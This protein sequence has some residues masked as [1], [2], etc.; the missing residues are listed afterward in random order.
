[1]DAL[2]DL[3][4]AG[5]SALFES[6]VQPLAFSLGLGHWLEIAFEGTGWLLV[7]LLQLAVML[8][9]ILP[10]ELW[11]PAEPMRDPGAVR[12]DVAYT[13]FHRLGVFRLLLFFTLDPLAD[14]LFG[15]LRAAG[16]SGIH[17]DDLWP[18]WSDQPAVA[19]VLYLLLFDAL[20]YAIHRGQHHWSWW[21]ALHALHHSQRQMTMWTDQRNHLLD[22]VLVAL[23]WAVVAQAVGMPPEQFVAVVAVTQLLENL[24]HANVRMSFG[25]WGERCLISPRFHRWHHSVGWGHESHARGTGV[26]DRLPLGGHNFGVLFPW[27]DDLLGTALR[28]NDDPTTGI[29]DQIEQ[30]RDYGRGVWAQQYLGL[31]RLWQALRQRP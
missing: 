8:L 29:R 21:W 5:Q 12:S 1:M 17:L 10:L 19:F 30:G 2:M 18:G 4:A 28:R 27:W 26:N 6:L 7:G 25:A 23:I 15:S 13:L 22:D 9:I 31:Q 11:R 14:G 16:W 24:Q 20:N 3:F